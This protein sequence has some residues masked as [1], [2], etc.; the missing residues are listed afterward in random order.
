M[1]SR[2]RVRKALNFEKTDRIPIDLGA[3]FCSGIH[4]HTYNQVRKLLGLKEQTSKVYEPMMFLAEVDE[5]VRQALGVD[6]VGVHNRGTLLGYP[7]QNWKEWKVK[8]DKYLFGDGFYTTENERGTWAYPQGVKTAKPSGWMA[9]TAYWFDPMARQEDITDKLFAPGEAR[10]DYKVNLSP[11]TDE[12]ARFI[13]EQVKYY[14]KNTDYS[15]FGNCCI[16]PIGDAF[17]FPCPW[18]LETPGLRKLEEWLIAHYEYDGYLK[19][20]YDMH[21]ESCMEN[22][23]I[24]AQAVGDRIDTLYMTSTDFG[25]Q[26]S[27]MLSPDIYKEYYKPYHK[28]VADWVHKNTNWKVWLHSCGAVEPIIEDFIDA[29]VDCLNPVQITAT[30]ME[31]EALVEKFGGRIVFWGGCSNT[32]WT[33][34]NGTVEEVEA[35][36]RRLASTL[37]SKGGLIGAA[38][39]NIQYNTP[40]ENIVKMFETIK[41]V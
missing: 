15:L 35:E 24:Y 6:I 34:Q 25:V 23:K 13:E 16:A 17:F 38:V 1:T 27:M 29:G 3:S 26:C 22:L 4:G 20:F 18:G 12:D 14:Y 40:A 37:N 5:D 33:L 41:S 36:T 8:G 2:E 30:G 32:Q 10:E 21:F 7:N 39:H 31:P 11:I 28:T 19:E 9:E